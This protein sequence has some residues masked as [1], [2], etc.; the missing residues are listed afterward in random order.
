MARRF[1]DE[2]A[3]PGTTITVHTDGQTE[4]IIECR[5][6]TTLVDWGRNKANVHKVL[7]GLRSALGS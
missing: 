5:V 7:A 3:F 1:Q 4:V 6:R 2:A